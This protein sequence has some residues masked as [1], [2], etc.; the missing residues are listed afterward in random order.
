[1]ELFFCLGISGLSNVSYGLVVCNDGVDRKAII[2]SIVKVNG[3]VFY[4]GN[5]KVED[6]EEINKN[7]YIYF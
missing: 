7:I 6:R 5:I 4:R 3:I 2:F 1:M